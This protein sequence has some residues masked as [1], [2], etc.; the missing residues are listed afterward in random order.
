[1]S[2]LVLN[3]RQSWLMRRAGRIFLVVI[4]RTQVVCSNIII[5]LHIGNVARRAS[6]EVSGATDALLIF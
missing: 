1:M 2:V 3:A 5:I 4:R 6:L